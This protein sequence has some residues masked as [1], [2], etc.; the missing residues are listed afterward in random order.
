MSTEWLVTLVP[1][2]V[3]GVEDAREEA[4]PK[5]RRDEPSCGVVHRTVAVVVALE[6]LMLVGVGMLPVVMV[7]EVDVA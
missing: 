7:R 3:S 2:F 5:K 4:I 1:V 6:V